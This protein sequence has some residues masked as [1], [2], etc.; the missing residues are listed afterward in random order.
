[1]KNLARLAA[2]MLLASTLAI[3]PGQAANKAKFSDY[4]HGKP[5]DYLP[6]GPGKLLKR[7]AV[8]MGGGIDV[9][10]ALAWMIAKMSQCGDGTTGKPGNFL[11][12]RAGGNPSYD[13]FIYK[14]GPL[15][16]VQTIVV[17]N[18]ETAN[19]PAVI[20]YVKNAGAIWLT[21]GDQGDYY[22]FWKGSRLVEAINTQVNSFGVP[23]GGTSAGMMI[24]SQIAY[25]AF[26]NTITSA[27][28]LADPYTA[29][30]VTLNNDFW[31]TRTPFPP[32][33]ATVTDSHFDTRDRMGRLLTFLA[34]SKVDGLAGSD[35]VKAI[36]VDQEAALLMESGW[37][38][39]D[40][41]WKIVANP[42]SAGA[43][44][45]LAPAA[46]SSLIVSPGTPLT[47]TNVR[48]QKLNAGALLEYSIDVEAGSM[49]SSSGSLY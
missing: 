39:R 25:I 10:D 26:P 8:L 17:P 7:T 34:R 33:I 23:I 36:G 19:D 49:T 46:N 44:Y 45:L 2:A 5:V 38:S 13:S 11:V 42:G 29:D 32:L 1:M 6:C 35:P 14:L 24:L 31:P 27:A 9:K 22:N 48:V 47:F 37:G 3:P 28:A 21:G 40:Y 12:V 41:S 4:Q 15:A 16:A 30:S 20:P 43:A 18:L